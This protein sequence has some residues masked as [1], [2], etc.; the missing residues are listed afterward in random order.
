KRLVAYLTAKEGEPLNVSELRTLLQAKLPAYMVPAAFVTL[1]RFA[2]TPNGKVDRLAL[3][4]PD[5][6]RPELEKAFVAPRTSIEK[7]LADIWCAVLGLK[8]VGVQDNFFE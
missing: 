8:S 4:A 1:E 6:P 7:V 5:L 2:L 3:P